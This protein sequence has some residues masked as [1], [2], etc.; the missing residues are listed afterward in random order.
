MKIG[1]CTPLDNLQKAAAWGYDYIE[2]GVAGLLE[3]PVEAVQAYR[4][5]AEISDIRPEAFNLLFPG[6]MHL[7]EEDSLDAVRQYLYSAFDRVRLLGGSL[8]VFGSGGVR[9]MPGQRPFADEYRQLLDVVKVIG[10]TAVQYDLQVVIEPLHTGETNCVNSTVEAAMLAAA[11]D[12]P[13]IGI[14]ADSYH[15]FEM[16]EPLENLRRVAAF[17][18]IHV[19]MPEGRAFPTVEDRQVRGFINTLQAIG[20][21]GRI[22]IEG[23]TADLDADAPRALATLRSLTGR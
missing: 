12:Q 5:Q 15:M 6:R 8:V 11:A 21:Q 7:Y 2:P 20:Y 18:H 14:M 4:A 10:E 16:N 13:P 22:S 1:L 3:M 19:A 9:K 23:N 17:G